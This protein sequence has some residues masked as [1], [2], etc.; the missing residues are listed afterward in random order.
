MHKKQKKASKLVKVGNSVFH[1]CKVAN[2]LFFS[3]ATEPS[4]VNDT[5]YAEV[6]ASPD[7]DNWKCILKFK[8]DILPM[9]YF[10][11]GQVFFPYI[12]KD[13]GNLWISPFSTK[14]SGKTIKLSLSKIAEIYNSSIIERV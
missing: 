10:Q 2:W 3:T 1:G 5:K 9:K 13:D 14:F 4:K 12:E 11:Y 7:G 8:K 6:W